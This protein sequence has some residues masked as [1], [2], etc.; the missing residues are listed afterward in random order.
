[1]MY[2]LNGAEIIFNPSATIGGL[3]YGRDGIL[4]T[5]D[6][7]GIR[8]ANTVVRHQLIRLGYCFREMVA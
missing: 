6:L 3:R 4:S 8:Y 5:T 1:M 2:A 7:P